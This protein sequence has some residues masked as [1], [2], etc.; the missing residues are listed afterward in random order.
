MHW[1]LL[2]LALSLGGCAEHSRAD[3]EAAN[4]AALNAFP[5]DYR[6]Q[7]LALLRAGLKDPN[8][9][10]ASISEPALKPVSGT[11]SRY[12]VCVRFNDRHT[13]DK[14]AVFFHGDVNQLI[15]ANPDQCGSVAYKSLVEPG[16]AQ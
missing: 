7:L 5:N 15:D 9:R 12:V 3:V 13:N 2:V 14:L 6:S 11:V 8:F 10:D 16:S 1:L 4:E